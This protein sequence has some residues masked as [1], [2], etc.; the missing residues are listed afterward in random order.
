MNLPSELKKWK[1][2]VSVFNKWDDRE[3]F[4]VLKEFVTNNYSFERSLK[5]HT[6]TILKELLQ[7]EE[8]G[9]GTGEDEMD[10][11]HKIDADD[12]LILMIDE[13][14]KVPELV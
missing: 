12:G 13:G 2:L 11:G 5:D 6:A 14:D 9:N 8:T 7:L 10:T 4:M 3:K 1:L